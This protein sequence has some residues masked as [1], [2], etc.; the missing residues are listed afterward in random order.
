ML[1]V[2]P[3][4]DSEEFGKIL[5]KDLRMQLE[6]YIKLWHS[7]KYIFLEMSSK[8][9]CLSYCDNQINQYL[10]SSR[11]VMFIYGYWAGHKVD[12]G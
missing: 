3:Q 2:M 12:L 1:E 5:N 4:V 6:L 11:L 8:K 9:C 7:S 10:F